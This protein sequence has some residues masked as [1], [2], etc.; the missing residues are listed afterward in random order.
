MIKAQY[1]ILKWY[2]SLEDVHFFNSENEA[3]MATFYKGNIPSFQF[4]TDGGASV[5]LYLIK[6]NGLTETTLSVNPVLTDET[7]YIRVKYSG[8]ILTGQDDGWYYLR[9]DIDGTSYYS[10]MFNWDTDV[11]KYLKITATSYDIHLGDN[12]K[13]LYNMDDYTLTGYF[14][15]EYEGIDLQNEE[16]AN[17][18]NGQI[19]PYYSGFARMRKFSIKGNESIFN[20]LAGLRV[21]GINGEITITCGNEMYKARD[22]SVEVSSQSGNFDIVFINLKF[23]NNS[24][25]I[26]PINV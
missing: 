7:D 1:G 16:E 11:S 26:T 2:E 9:C 20:F 22:V 15:F 18:E 10:D 4:M 14:L 5:S 25:I 24:D 8:S 3:I 6:Y 17:E 23:V 19:I 13:Y 12:P 21:L